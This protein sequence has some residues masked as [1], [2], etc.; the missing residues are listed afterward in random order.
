L[1]LA[2]LQHMHMQLD[3][4]GF[5]SSG[6]YTV[7]WQNLD[8]IAVPEPSSLVLVGIGTAGLIFG[9]RRINSRNA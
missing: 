1:N 9:R 5:G 3:P 2:D 6:A 4:G 8:L 7:S